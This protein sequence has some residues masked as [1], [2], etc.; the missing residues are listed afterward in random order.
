MSLAGLSID[1]DHYCYI[2]EENIQVIDVKIYI[3][4]IYGNKGEV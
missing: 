2:D 1:N 3:Y 4:R